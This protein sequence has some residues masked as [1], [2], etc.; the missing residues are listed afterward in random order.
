MRRLTRPLALSI[1]VTCLLGAAAAA[2]ARTI[3]WDGYRWDVRSQGL[4]QPGPNL[5]SDSVANAHVDRRSG[6]MMLCYTRNASGR[7]TSTELDNERHLGYGTYRW[8]VGTNVSGLDANEVLGLFTYDDYSAPSYNEID[9]EFSHFGD[10]TNPLGDLTVWINQNTNVSDESVFGYPRSARSTIDSFTW[11]PGKIAYTIRNGST[12]RIIRAW[13]AR[14]RIPVPHRE[15]PVMNWW[16]YNNA[17]PAG[18]VGNC[19]RV[20]S[21]RFTRWR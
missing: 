1:F 18:R 5:W 14:R 3:S 20:Q 12:G 4:T 2:T 9:I 21:F 13:T 15:V 10:P 17:A 8:V 7:W 19:V 6:A 11:T 16:R